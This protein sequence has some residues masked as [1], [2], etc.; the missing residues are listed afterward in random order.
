MKVVC[1]P[2]KITNPKEGSFFT[3]YG[4]RKFLTDGHVGASITPIIKKLRLNPAKEAWDFLSIALSVI[5]ADESTPRTTQDGWTREID[6]NVAVSNIKLWDQHV[7]VLE[8]ALRFLSTDRWKISL[9]DGGFQ[10]KPP[11]F[12]AI[13]NEDCIC[14]L[15]GGLDSLVGAIDLKSSG[16]HPAFVSQVAKGDKANQK[17]LGTSVSPSSLHLQ[18]N[19]N[20]VPPSGQSERSQRARSLVFLAYGVLAAT[21]LKAY[22]QGKTIDLYM[23]ENGFISL[24]IPLTPLRLASHSTRTTHPYFISAIQQLLN[25]VGLRVRIVNPY[26]FLTK[27][28]MLLQ[29]KDQALLTKLA[30]GSTSCGRFARHAFQHCG[31]C[32]PCQIRRAAFQKWGNDPTPRYRYSGTGRFSKG[33]KK[34]DDVRSVGIAVERVRLQGLESWIGGGLTSVQMA[35]RNNYRDVVQRGLLELGDF[36]QAQGVL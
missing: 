14:L 6:L 16:A 10:P 5:A 8:E 31:R 28:E 33:F 3:L 22:G 2:K 18:L 12:P 17:L 20:A 30:G 7:P 4:R 29:C 19:H 26:K 15:S 27:G 35:D 21:S 34:F 36:L 1:A 9:V 25:D 24:N 32:V 13:L 23:P 11:R